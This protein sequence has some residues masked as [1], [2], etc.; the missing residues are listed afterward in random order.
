MQTD[1]GA[2]HRDVLWNNYPCERLHA[3]LL[4]NHARLGAEL[5]ECD[6]AAG[7]PRGGDGGFPLLSRIF[8]SS[9]IDKKEKEVDI[10][11][12]KAFGPL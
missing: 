11:F 9:K 5:S 6:G 3:H 10:L 4:Q 7:W 8:G 12:K 1:V 2:S